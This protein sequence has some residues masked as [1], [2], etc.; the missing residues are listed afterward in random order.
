MLALVGFAGILV[1]GTI[2]FTLFEPTVN[3]SLWHG[4]Y[5]TLVTVTTVGYGDYFPTTDASRVIASVVMI[6]G[7]GSFLAFLQSFFDLAI[8]SDI[9]RELGLPMRGTKMKDHYIICGFGNVGRQIMEQLKARGEKFV[10]VERDRSKVEKLVQMNVPVIEGDAELDE[11]LERANV[12]EAKGLLTTMPDHENLIVVITARNLNPHLFIVSEVE[13][14]I[15]SSKMKI[16]GANEVVQCHEMGAR[17]MVSKVCRVVTDPVCG[18]DVDPT[19]TKFT[20]SF[21]GENF[22]FDSSECMQ[23]FSQ[24][25]KKYADMKKLLDSTCQRMI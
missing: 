18:K 17:M 4:F 2:G 11:T 24:E 12:R 6:G 3:G 23:R 9:R 13:D 1:F 25:P 16:A 7:I 8:S 15:H 21:E 20:T 22:F 5:L 19:K 14:D 10:I